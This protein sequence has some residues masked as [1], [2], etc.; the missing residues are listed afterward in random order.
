MAL[1]IIKCNIKAAMPEWESRMENVAAGRF[2]PTATIFDN[3]Q[4]VGG[5]GLMAACYLLFAGYGHSSCNLA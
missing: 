5:I 2:T 1:P 4:H 3:A